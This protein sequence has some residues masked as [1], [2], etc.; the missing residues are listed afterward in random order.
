MSKFEI[1]WSITVFIFL[2]SVIFSAIMYNNCRSLNN[3]Q[4]IT[5]SRVI[6]LEDAISDMESLIRDLDRVQKDIYIQE[7]RLSSLESTNISLEILLVDGKPVAVID[8]GVYF[9]DE[10]LSE[11]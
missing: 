6:Y 3:E 5:N 8:D 9:T 10:I 1:W 7:I 11:D 2:L 4:K